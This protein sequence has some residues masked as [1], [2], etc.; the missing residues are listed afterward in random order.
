M[1]MIQPNC[2]VQFG[3]EDIEFNL[4]VLGPSIGTSQCLV[5]LL[6]NEESR[7]LID[8]GAYVSGKNP[9]LDT[10][11]R[12][13]PEINNFLRQAVSAKSSFDETLQSLQSIA[14]RL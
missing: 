8:L 7:D 9:R 10:A 13:Q 14:A 4:S 2:R 12:L 5:K 6:A 1:K 3:A 11:L